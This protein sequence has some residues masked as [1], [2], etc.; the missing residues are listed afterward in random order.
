MTMPVISTE[1]DRSQNSARFTATGQS[2]AIREWRGSGPATLQGAPEMKL[3]ILVAALAFAASAGAQ[4]PKGSSAS[5]TFSACGGPAHFEY[6]VERIAR[7][8]PDSTLDV[9]PT[10][11]AGTGNVVQFVARKVVNAEDLERAR[12]ILSRW[13][14]SP[15]LV[16][17]RPTCQIVMTYLKRR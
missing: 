12:T 11:T 7:L 17:G 14:Y 8:L 13:R 2:F 4:I 15:A 6:Q 9:A 1:L 10:D 3:P 5:A 16:G